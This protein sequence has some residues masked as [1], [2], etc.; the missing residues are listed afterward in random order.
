[1][2]SRANEGCPRYLWCGINPCPL[3]TGFPYLQ[4]PK[5]KSCSLPKATRKQLAKG[6]KNLHYKGLTLKEKGKSQI[7]AVEST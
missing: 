4:L 1:M 3:S 2:E 5:E 7:V 6:F